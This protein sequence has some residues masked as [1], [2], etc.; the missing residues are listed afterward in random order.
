MEIQIKKFHQLSLDQLYQLLKL[1]VEAFVVEQECPYPELDNADQNAVHFIVEKEERVI[2]YLRLFDLK[3]DSSKI[4]R[5]V[6]AKDHRGEGISRKLVEAALSQVKKENKTNSVVLQS[7]EYLT[8]FYAS[9]GFEKTSDVY[10]E[11]NIPHVDM[12]L[13]IKP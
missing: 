12:Q 4:S 9:F 8:D 10:L 1:R 13:T 11:D 6:T 7:Q 5:V 2:G 3:N